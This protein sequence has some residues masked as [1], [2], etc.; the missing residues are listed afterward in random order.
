MKLIHE[1]SEYPSKT[2]GCSNH[3]R[4]RAT[5][6]DLGGSASRTVLVEAVRVAADAG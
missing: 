5:A 6:V 1:A 3:R 4:C 2:I